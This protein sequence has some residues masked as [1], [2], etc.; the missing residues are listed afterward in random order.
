M[1]HLVL[2][3]GM[4]A[5]ALLASGCVGVGFGDNDGDRMAPEITAIDAKAAN[6]AL[7]AAAVNPVPADP[8]L[9]PGG[10]VVVGDSYIV[11]SPVRILDIRARDDDS[12]IGRMNVEVS[13]ARVLAARTRPSER[14]T[15]VD[16]PSA[17][18]STRVSAV[19]SL[20]GSDQFLQLE[21]ALDPLGPDQAV[22]VD[23]VVGDYAGRSAERR[24]VRF[25]SVAALCPGS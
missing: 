5:V 23:V 20:V 13:G 2:T 12:G 9:C 1:K 8:G 17:L 19:G 7:L 24:Q 16:A 25:G 15:N 4:V 22:V 21:I 6:T 3:G 10:G 11:D 14:T 18:G